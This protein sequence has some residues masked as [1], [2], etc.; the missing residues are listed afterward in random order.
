[1]I[2]DELEYGPIREHEFEALRELLAQALHFTLEVSTTWLERVG[3]SHLRVVRQGGRVAAG[4]GLIEMGQ[5]FGGARVPVAAITAVGVAPER[6]G[7][8]VG[9]RLMHGLLDEVY[10]SGTP[11]STLYPSTLSFYR[12]VGYERAGSVIT[13]EL[14]IQTITRRDYAL[15]MEL[16]P[17][18]DPAPL[19]PIYD[20][21]A[22]RTPGMFDRG[23]FIW[24]AIL[25]PSG[26]P[27]R[28]YLITRAGAPEGYLT[29]MQG[30]RQDPLRIRD[31]ALLSRA[32]GERALTFLADHRSIVDQVVWRGA[33]ADPLA[34]LLPEQRHKISHAFDWVL[35]IVDVA[36][37]L[38]RRGYPP[39][40]QAE[41][42]LDVHDDLLTHNTGRWQL[43]VAEGRAEVRPG[44]AG[45]IKLGIRELA[46]LYTGH[47]S[48]AALQFSGALSGSDE[49]LALL[50]LVFSGEPP[51]LTDPF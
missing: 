1:M 10:A 49:D 11:I 44:G 4:L 17:P 23:S 31:L 15:E 20:Q 43:S 19:A 42:H 34:A 14:P 45:R 27:A 24:Q 39:G 35:R 8:G 28:T 16:A 2:R 5:W 21:L 13:Y 50:A 25:E 51:R 18:G 36:G 26:A 30:A 37:A 29:L 41:L 7:R 48:P 3:L 40:L 46:A 47:L 38:S 6:R 9:R 33:P 32:A 12:A 22:Q